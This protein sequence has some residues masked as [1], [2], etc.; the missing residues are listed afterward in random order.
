VKW[1]SIVEISRKENEETIRANIQQCWAEKI[2][3]NFNK[4]R[5]ASILK[6]IIH[7]L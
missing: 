3:G 1:H 2:H 5:K 6:Q 4:T 7:F